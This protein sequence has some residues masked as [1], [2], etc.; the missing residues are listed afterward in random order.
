VES[1]YNSEKNLEWLK[2]GNCPVRCPVPSELSDH[3]HYIFDIHDE[4][5]NDPEWLSKNINDEKEKTQQKTDKSGH[6]SDSKEV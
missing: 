2:E 6:I 5:D 3:D 4:S 1:V